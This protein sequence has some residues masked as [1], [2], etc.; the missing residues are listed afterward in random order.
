MN[1]KIEAYQY[2]SISVTF[3]MYLLTK[4]KVKRLVIKFKKKVTRT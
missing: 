4:I 1:F 2:S 3:G